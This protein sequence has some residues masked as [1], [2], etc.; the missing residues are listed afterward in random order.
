MVLNFF[1]NTWIKSTTKGCKGS[2]VWWPGNGGFS[3]QADGFLLSLSQW[4]GSFFQDS[5]NSQKFWPVKM[6]QGLVYASHSLP[7]RVNSTAYSLSNLNYP[8]RTKPGKPLQ[9]L[10]WGNPVCLGLSPYYLCVSL[11][12]QHV[13]LV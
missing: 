7:F 2:Y 3:D 11:E 4:I 13:L 1:M 10:C 9:N 8:K 12:M 5:F 6:T